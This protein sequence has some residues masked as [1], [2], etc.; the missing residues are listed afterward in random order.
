MKY[1]IRNKRLIKS[2]NLI[3]NIPYCENSA[4]GMR[5]SICSEDCYKYGNCNK[6]AY[7]KYIKDKHSRGEGLARCND[8]SILLTDEQ[9]ETFVEDA[10]G[11]TYRLCKKCFNARKNK[12]NS[13]PNDNCIKFV[14]ED[15]EYSNEEVIEILKK[16]KEEEDKKYHKCEKCGV[17]YLENN[18]F[19]M[20]THNLDKKP[21]SCHA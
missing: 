9:G 18:T 21:D 6:S 20:V 16:H 8:C 14:I 17:R 7:Y 4:I 1:K 5:A 3:N 11:V 12:E 2:N 15:K 13:I 19:N 10:T